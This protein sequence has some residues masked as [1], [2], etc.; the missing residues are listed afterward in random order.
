M[1]IETDR[2]L[3]KEINESHIDDILKIRSNE[4]I[5]QYV[6]RNSPKNNYDALEFIL[7]IR[8]K[9][10]DKEMIFWGISDKGQRNLIGTICLWNFSQDRKTAEIGYELLPEYHRMGVMTEALRSVLQY[11]FT[12]LN[13][14]EVLAFTDKN[15]KSSQRLLIK[16]GF[17]L[18]ETKDNGEKNENLL[19]MLK[20]ERMKV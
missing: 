17:V 11:G 7:H 4:M 3:L 1:E 5:N 20:N 13:L 15:N 10:Q 18:Q 8:K 2:L 14:Q 9:T 12:I 19:F 6:K 16:G